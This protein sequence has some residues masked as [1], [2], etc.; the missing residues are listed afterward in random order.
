MHELLE[1]LLDE[2]APLG[3]YFQ[4]ILERDSLSVSLK[5]PA[6]QTVNDPVQQLHQAIAIVLSG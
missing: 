1:E 2:L 3:P 5:W 6:Q 4:V